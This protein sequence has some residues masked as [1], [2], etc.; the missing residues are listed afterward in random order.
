MLIISSFF[1]S[2]S[3]N[4]FT[5]QKTHKFSL[6]HNKTILDC[7][8]GVKSWVLTTSFMAVLK[9]TF[10]GEVFQESL[11]LVLY[12]GFYQIFALLSRHQP[13][14]VKEKGIINLKTL[15]CPN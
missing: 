1:I 13:Q 14:G 9:E 7:L 3:I 11:N 10:P 15:P 12:D 5:E 8:R 6:K 2:G 4:D